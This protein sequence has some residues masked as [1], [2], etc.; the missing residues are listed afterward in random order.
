[1]ESKI[2]VTVRMKPSETPPIPALWQRIGDQTLMNTRTKELYTYDRVYCP[3]TTTK[4]IF[5]TQVKS[6]VLNSLKG[7]NQTVFA[8]GQT[9]SGKTFTMR[10]PQGK[11]VAPG[12]EIGLVQL[13]VEALFQHVQEDTENDY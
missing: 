4:E 13:S 2:N 1:M 7:I 6:L 3:E 8:Y 5:D 11:E 12:Q 10:G 9:S